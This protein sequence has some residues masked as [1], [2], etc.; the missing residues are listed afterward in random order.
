MSS[1]YD[2]NIDRLKSRERTVT[3][4]SINQTMEMANTMGNR[5]IREAGQFQDSLNAFS[6]T[7]QK[8][9][10]D[11]KDEAH[12]RGAMMAQ[13]Q[14]EI[15][16]EKLVELQNQLGTLTEEDTRY[17]EMKA[18]M[19]KLSGPDIYPEA[20]RLTKMSNWEQAGYMK[21]KLTAF[22]DT[23]ADKLDHAMMTSEK[24]MQIENITFTPKELH[25]NN[26]HGMPFKE[27]AVQIIA[28]DIRR[29]AGLHKFSPE[30][31]ELA[32]T[33][34][35]IQKAKDQAIARYRERYNIESSSQTRSKAE[36]TWKT[37][38][39]TGEDI[40]HYLVKTGATMDG[41][42]QLV[43]NTGAWEALE[44]MIVTEGI[45]NNDS[46]Y[47]AQILNQP[48]PDRLA[49]KLGAKPGT[50]YAQQWPNK[51]AGLQ[52]QIKDGYT[53]KIDNDLKNLE[54]AGTGVE[55]EFIE[56][57]RNADLTAAEVNQ[58]KRQF[59]ELGLTIPSSVTN[60]E[61]ASDRNEREDKDLIEALMASQNG[62]ISNEQLDAFHPKA[63]L[64]HREKASK[65]EKAALQEFGSEKKIKAALDKTWESMGI[66]GNEKSLDYI[67]AFENAKVDYA[68]KYNQYVAMGYSPA[69]ASHYALHAEQVVNPETKEPIPDSTGVLR[70]IE[71]A[72]P[73]NKYV[74]IGQNIEKTAKEGD[75]R[76]V[77]IRMSKEQISQN[78]NIMTKEVIGGS[79]G[80]RQ[81]NKIQTNIEKYG[82]RGLYMDQGAL[83]YYKGIA[84]G[85]NPREGGWWGIVDAQLKA[86][87]YDKG[88]SQ[89]RP[90]AVDFQT[91]IDKDGNVI[92][93]PRGS[94]KIDRTI[95]RTF[96][97]KSDE[98]VTH[99]QKMLI[100]SQRFGRG[101]SVWDNEKNWQSYLIPG[102]LSEKEMSAYLEKDPRGITGQGY[103]LDLPDDPIQRRRIQEAR[104]KAELPFGA[105]R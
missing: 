92:P 9:R 25:D 24:A 71:Q 52:Q 75:M 96:A 27:A 93:N 5:G 87:G 58:Y 14:A 45:N 101:T 19:L 49:K 60:Y 51:V 64:E 68:E 37:S 53:K 67:E 105:I 79:Y 59:G 47:A 69:H 88:L 99:I 23:F 43:G 86:N 30:L 66:K 76:V 20:D 28:K 81:I 29:N 2:R 54:A 17:H 70:E 32:G 83:A 18:E 102:Y 90:R 65:L 82:P 35:A 94:Q 44:S 6:K 22:N 38:Q 56:K 1:S 97:N 12:E 55:V 26:I 10:Q 11:Q 98:T 95:A 34:E 36:M 46:G 21:Q 42:N 57:A 39:K 61:T 62:Y 31:L 13:E 100:D 48:M 72:G 85:R 7:L 40:Y 73:G 15:N 33:N 91:G 77:Q 80:Q 104:R 50:T 63:A 16:A 103:K 74:T 4:Q 3:Q 8:I 89:S 84:R 78:P 41:N